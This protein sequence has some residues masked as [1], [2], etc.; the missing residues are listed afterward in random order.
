M[1][2]QPRG[3]ARPVS[4]SKRWK[5]KI[6]R[7]CITR[8]K[9]GNLTEM[10]PQTLINEELHR[11]GVEVTPCRL[12]MEIETDDP[13]GV[14]NYLMEE[15]LFDLLEEVEQEMAKADAILLQEGLD[16][17]E[18][19]EEYLASRISEYYEEDRHENGVFCPVCQQCNLVE[20]D[21]G[22]VCPNAMDGESCSVRLATPSLEDL[23]LHLQRAYE[24]H[25]QDC[26]GVLEFTS[27]LNGLLTACTLCERTVRIL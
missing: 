17:K 25:S 22:V 20:T 24:Q 10:T 26:E 27:S 7:S 11:H 16:L 2:P 13:V 1:T 8:L 3:K 14:E 15:D 5:D 9:Q 23:K 6:R 19:E 4:A 18:Q 12:D 21:D